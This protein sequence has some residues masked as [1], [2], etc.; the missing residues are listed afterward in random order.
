MKKFNS[1][2]TKII[3]LTLVL[4]A[5][6]LLVVPPIIG[7][8]IFN[9]LH[10]IIVVCISV[11]ILTLFSSRLLTLY[12]IK[13]IVQIE[14]KLRLAASGNLIE[15]RLDGKILERKDEYG[16]LGSNFNSMLLSMSDIIK[17]VA[18]EAQN[19]ENNVKHVN[20]EIAEL[21]EGLSVVS[22][23]T[24]AL[25][26]GME[27]TVASTQE[28]TSIS[29]E[30]EKAIESVAAKAQEG[31]SSANDISKRVVLLR[32]DFDV[33]YK[34][35]IEMYN[36]VKESMES[37]LEEAKAVEQ[38]NILADAILQITSQTNLLALNAAI[39]AAR[40][41]EAG[42]GFS[43]VADEIRKLAEDSKETATRIQKVTENVIS[44]V[45]NLSSNS[46]KLLDFMSSEVIKDYKTMLQ[47]VEDYNND[48]VNINSMTSDLFSTSEQLA[49][50]IQ[51]M[52]RAIQEINSAASDGASGTADIADKSV[53]MV[54]KTKEVINKVSI[55]KSSFDKLKEMV[56]TFKV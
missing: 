49:A 7:V 41:G 48:A 3:L 47:S 45:S 16:K 13:P 8:S 52:V 54:E 24:E 50:S 26:A 25:S 19:V 30:I 51:N 22:S 56:D 20:D 40:A 27:Q 38:I 17:G 11:I 55:T 46:V 6:P 39:E 53:T 43:V 33:T 1:L 35:V 5:F 31:A 42:R 21:N 2:R 36:S 9:D 4:T 28:M 44:S 29:T 14:S 10:E 23:T 37:A 12:I 34:E 18:K 15:S 32:E